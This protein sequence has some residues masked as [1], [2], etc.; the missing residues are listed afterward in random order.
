[1]TYFGLKNLASNETFT[2]SDPSVENIRVLV[3]EPQG[4]DKAARRKWLSEIKTK[5]CVFS[6]YEAVNP[7]TRETS[8]QSRR[9]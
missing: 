3:D 1:M 2:F 9:R 4:M 8:K 7:H 5:H 6:L